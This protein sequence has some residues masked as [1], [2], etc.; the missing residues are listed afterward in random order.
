M[1]SGQGFLCV[2]SI[3]ER[4]SFEEVNQFREQILRVKDVDSIPMVVA[5]NKCD[6]ESERQVSTAEGKNLAKNWNV[7]FFETSAKLRK[8]VDECFH[9][10]VREIR[11]DRKK[12]NDAQA[13]E[14]EKPKKKEKKE[15]KN[16]CSIL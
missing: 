12:A 5:G 9:Q 1:R 16:K 10:L 4:K 15:K 6:L 11:E 2:F 14:A 7:P 8:C 3:T 13:A